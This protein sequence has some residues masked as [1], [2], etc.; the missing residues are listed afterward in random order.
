MRIPARWS[1][2]MFWLLVAVVAGAHVAVLWQSIFIVRL[3]EDEAFNLTVPLNVLRGLGYTSDG[4]L[5]G[6]E[7]TSFDPRISTGPVVLLPI[8]AVMATGIDAIIA[9][10]LTVAAF[11]I[12]LLVG[13]AIVGRRIAGPWAALAAV[14]VPLAIDTTKGFSPIQGPADILG[15]IPVAALCVWAIVVLRRHLWMAGLLLG[16]AIQAKYIAILFIPAFVV[17]SWLRDRALPPR[18][19]LRALILP[20]ALV[21]APTAVVELTAMFALGPAGFVDHLRRTAGFLRSGGQ[22][23]APTTVIEKVTT[24]TESWFLP[25]ALVALVIVGAIAVCAA[26]LIIVRRDPTRLRD[27]VIVASRRE[28]LGLAIVCVGGLMTF[29]GWWSFAAHLPLWIRHPSPALFAL[30]PI[31]AAFLVLSLRVLGTRAAVAGGLVLAMMLGI[32][33]GAHVRQA[34]AGAGNETLADQRSTAA[35]L[36][37]LGGDMYA[38]QWGGPVSI[39]VISGAH[40]GLWDAGDHVADWPRLLTA[41]TGECE[42]PLITIGAYAVCAP[43]SLPPAG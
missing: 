11:Y 35:Q 10:R 25:P 12:A 42:P 8:A 2:I 15:E 24:L 3:W 13:V 39:V 6:S 43:T 41:V 29:L 40:V 22:S 37:A 38:A 17:A 30:A 5:S 14:T 36:A 4:T 23:Y 20:A 32:A 7:L 21:V 31:A 28:L 18:E 27:G 26:A 33:A 34:W 16:F 19:R 1:A 9:G